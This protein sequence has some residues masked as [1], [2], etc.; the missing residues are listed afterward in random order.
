MYKPRILG[1]SE[2]KER[3]NNWIV[4]ATGNNLKLRDDVTR[5]S[6]LARMDARVE[7]PELRTFAGNPLEKVLRGRGLY[8]WATLT[9]VRAY[10]VA[11]MPGR[12]PG[13][14]DTFA[15]WSDLVRSALVWLGRADPVETMKAIRANDPAYLARRAMFHAIK[16]AYGERRAAAGQMVA[17]AKSGAIK[18][19]GKGVLDQKLSQEAENLK[20]AITIYTNSK[21]DGQYL[22]NKLNRDRGNIADGLCLRADYDNHNKV[23]L[24]YVEE[25]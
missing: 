12:L 15:E 8:I 7:Q 20:T 1:K 18:Q 13:I 24:W 2:M 22:G 16:N 21:L 25:I 4:Y 11:G 9:V 10:L 5:R 6:L 23:N 17:D 14:G 3:R 19:P